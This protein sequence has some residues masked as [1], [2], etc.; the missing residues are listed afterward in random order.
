MSSDR[1]LVVNVSLSNLKAEIETYLRRMKLVNDSEDIL[2]ITFGD[3]MVGEEWVS[4]K[5]QTAKTVPVIL[6]IKGDRG[7]DIIVHK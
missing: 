1:T 7:C 6:K 2:D 3:V 5:W 4:A